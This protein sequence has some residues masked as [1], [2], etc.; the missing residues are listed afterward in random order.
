VTAFADA[1]ALGTYLGVGDD[2]DTDR[3]DLVLALASDLIRASA[4]QTLH[5][6]EDD[7][8]IVWPTGRFA[9]LPELPVIAV[10]KVEQL[11][12]DG[13]SWLDVSLTSFDF[14]G[15]GTIV[16]P[17]PTWSS[18]RWNPR[19]VRVTY[20]HGYDT[21]PGELT[22]VTLSLAARLYANPIGVASEGMGAH[23][24]AY[25]NAGVVTDAEAIVI[26]HYALGHVG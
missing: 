12:T 9:F 8:V 26:G 22:A 15:D 20:T 24:A 7:V 1:P 11:N 21:I 17:L 16:L 3:A 13:A 14:W 4:G 5:R 10:S 6:V 23:S 25:P 18:R 19:A 2:L